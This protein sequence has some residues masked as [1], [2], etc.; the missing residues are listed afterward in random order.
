MADDITP[1]SDD[2]EHD[3]SSVCLSL[4]IMG[5]KFGELANAMASGD[6]PAHTAFRLRSWARD[7]GE[8]ADAVEK[9][10]QG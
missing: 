9:Q 6:I 1:T 2:E 10:T 7:L 4:D 8:M 5:R 3:L